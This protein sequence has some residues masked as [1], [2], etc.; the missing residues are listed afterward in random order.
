MAVSHRNAETSRVAVG[1]AR[2]SSDKQDTSVANQ[3]TEIERWARETTHQL[4]RVF[5][6]DGIS[7]SVLDRPGLAALLRYVEAN[8]AGG[9]V[10]LWRRNRLARPDDPIDGLLLER[11]IR[12]AGTIER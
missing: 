3:R 8:P 11:K 12:R 1:L 6:D 7:G 9:V 2:A 4:V 10:C 5:E